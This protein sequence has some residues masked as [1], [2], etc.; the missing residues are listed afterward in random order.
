LIHLFKSTLVELGSAWYRIFYGKI[1]HLTFHKWMYTYSVFL[2]MTFGVSLLYFIYTFL[3]PNDLKSVL[4]MNEKKM[5]SY[6][7]YKELAA[8]K[9]PLMD[10]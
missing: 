2:Y 9:Q 7:K 6:N 5:K 3:Y 8:N 10:N 4:R 1:N